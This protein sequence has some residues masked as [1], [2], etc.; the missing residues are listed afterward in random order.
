MDRQGV[1]VAY[2]TAVAVVFVGL[3]VLG[4][5]VKDPG[6]G[7]P[8]G[9]PIQQGHVVVGQTPVDRFHPDAKLDTSQVSK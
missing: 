4:F 8:A 6:N 3:G 1:A 5:V 7:L 9:A 2:T